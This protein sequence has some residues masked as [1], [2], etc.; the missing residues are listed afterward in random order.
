M[1]RLPFDTSMAGPLD[2]V[3]ITSKSAVLGARSE[4]PAER[5]ESFQVLIA[6]YWK[7]VY[8]V[9]RMRWGK[10]NEDAKDLTQEFF[11]RAM[12][13]DFFGSYDPARSRFRTFI[14]V[15]LKG[16][17]ANQDVAAHRLKRGGQHQ[18]LTMDFATAE[19]ELAHA[20][21]AAPETPEAYFEQEWIRSLFVAAVDRLRG[22]C[23]ARGKD[24]QLRLFE[25]YDLA[26]SG[27]LRPTY[28][29]LAQESGISLADVNNHL[30]AI[31]KR[32]R[33][34]LLTELRRITASDQEFRD[35]AREIL[36][37]GAP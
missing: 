32:F 30:V 13:K 12:E 16:F 28:A 24:L 14:M 1:P 31:R 20:D 19:G 17:L 15:C 37:E 9:I 4:E 10:T 34:V 25:R 2:D 27:Q 23:A 11:A 21:P 29:D 36:G 6:A 7:P 18:V 8:K 22:E 5:K 3:P 26:E 33:L 35:E